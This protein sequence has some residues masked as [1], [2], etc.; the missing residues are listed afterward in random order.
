MVK[1]L[2]ALVKE[3]RP[4]Q[5]I[6]NLAVFAAIIFTGQLFNSGPFTTSLHAF[7]IFCAFSS[8]TY[9]FNDVLDI[10]RDQSH[11]LKKF[12]PVASGQISVPMALFFAFILATG[13]ILASITI[14]PSF[15]L[16]CLT[17]LGLQLAYSLSLKHAAVLD[18]LAIASGYILRVL[19]GEFATGF[20]V[21]FWL[22]IC[23]IS[24]S[25]FLAI[26]KRRA[27]LTSLSGFKDTTRPAL[28]HYSKG[29]LDVYLSMFANSTWFSYALFTFL[30]PPI[31]PRNPFFYFI[32]DLFPAGLTRKWLVI[33]IPFVIYG[34][35]RYTQLIFD[36]QQG[37]SP[38]KVLLGDKPLLV[39]I[40]IWVLIV[41]FLIYVVGK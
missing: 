24:L 6:K 19:A 7:I 22:L 3:A 14:M 8:A 39:T 40:M 38:E 13:G 27:E 30:E 35:M 37:E 16:I 10:K 20:H 4:R 34:L 33:T 17:Y 2:F 21:T 36:K 9:M 12:R 15:F 23:V 26:G 31:A 1:L 18:I 41:V 5:W 28:E 29:L 11:P 32:E 25:L